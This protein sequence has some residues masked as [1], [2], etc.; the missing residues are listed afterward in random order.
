LQVTVT[1]HLSKSL[2]F[3]GAYTFSK[4]LGYIDA[5]GPAAYYTSV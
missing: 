4:A 3:L 2:G 5:N 1:K